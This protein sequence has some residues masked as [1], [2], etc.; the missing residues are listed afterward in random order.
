MKLKG[1]IM[2][3]LFKK[4]NT[5]YLSVSYKGKRKSKSL[6]TKDYNVALH[7][8]P[9]VEIQLLQQV[10]GLYSS[11]TELRFYDLVE[12][13]LKA[14]QSW[15]TATYK[16]NKYILTSHIKGKSLPTNPTSR[17]IHIRHINQCWN[18]GLKNKLINKADKLPGDTKGESRHRTYTDD[19]LK[20]MFSSI[21]DNSFNTFV[22]FAYYTGA[23]S[24]EIRS[25]SRDNLLDTS[26]V[27][28]GK[29]GL[30]YV[31]LNSQAI[32]VLTHQTELWKYTKDYVSHKFKKEVRRL[33]IKNARF[34]DLRRTFG[35]NLIKQGMSIFKVSKL[36]GHKSVRTTEQHYAPLLTVEIEDFIL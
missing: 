7:I 8:K 22:Q 14:P 6:N 32:T 23:R 20:L 1:K 16:L 15:S 13:F 27:V 18:W 26:L 2:A 29:T 3:S 31:K 33:G 10:M 17:A 35:L 19:E 21:K 9:S 34:H 11:N 12:Q 30:R 24:G 28:R 4:K 5:W 25:I 36:L